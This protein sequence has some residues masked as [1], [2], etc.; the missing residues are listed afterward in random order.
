MLI[1]VQEATLAHEPWCQKLSDEED[2]KDMTLTNE[3]VCVK[4][5]DRLTEEIKKVREVIEQIFIEKGEGEQL[6]EK[7]QE[8]EERRTKTEDMLR[9]LKQS[10]AATARD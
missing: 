10:V 9:R 2:K 4:I 7:L 5:L 6:T 1:C 3:K 8:F